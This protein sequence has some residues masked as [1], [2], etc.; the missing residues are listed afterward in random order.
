MKVFKKLFQVVVISLVLLS[1]NP[2]K[3]LQT[4]TDEANKE[5]NSNNYELA[6]EKYSTLFEKYKQ[7]N[8]EIPYGLYVNYANSAAKT[9]KY[10][11]AIDNYKKALSD[12]VSV[13]LV[14]GLVEASEKTPKNN[15]LGILDQYKTYLI[16]NGEEAYYNN[17]VFENAVKNGSQDI[18]VSSYKNLKTP[19]E[20]Q[21]MEYIKALETLGQK[22]EAI[23][24]CNELV[25][26]NPEYFKAKEYRGEYYYNFAEN[27]YKSEMDKYNKDKNYTAYVYL[28][29]ELK[30]ISS[31]YKIAKAEYE[32]LHTKYPEEKKYIKYL[33]N[34]YLRLEMKNE[35]SEM[36]KLLK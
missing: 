24:F 16:D 29:R 36:D 22:K 3:Q 18:I 9:G 17:K 27:W 30:K 2:L 35:A 11:V 19:T 21:S 8:V 33:K 12:S 32:A 25:K 7:S 5:F 31:N 23:N 28:K 34:I 14:K 4:A 6:F 15:L 10:E 13:N 1:C 20:V 26:N